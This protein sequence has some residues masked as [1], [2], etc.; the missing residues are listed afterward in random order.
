MFSADGRFVVTLG[1]EAPDESRLGT[2]GISKMTKTIRP[3]LHGP[4]TLLFAL[5]ICAEPVVGTTISVVILPQGVVTAADGKTVQYAS[6]ERVPPIGRVSKKLRLLRHRIVI[7][8]YG[9]AKIGVEPQPA[10]YLGSFFDS[11]EKEVGKTTTVSEVSK[12]IEK[13][14]ALAMSGFN[15]L[16]S[17]GTIS[18]D[19]FIE[20]TGSDNPL[21]GFVVTGYE[22]GHATVIKIEVEID[23]AAARLRQPEATLLY[24]S[25]TTMF[26]SDAEKVSSL[27]PTWINC[28]VPK[29][30][31]ATQRMET[32]ARAIVDLGI[33]INEVNV[34]LPITSVTLFPNGSYRIRRYHSRLPDLCVSH[35]QKTAQK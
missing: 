31:A 14:A 19:V 30:A 1:I 18:K 35:S 21:A 24:P 23:W 26:S 34:G 15:Q 32:T 28:R 27:L 2:N 10:Y 4:G 17:S 5:L 20:Q 9:V 6:N 7:G 33:E 3:R 12:L 25:A 8:S 22:S 16:M 29:T 11:I 13:R